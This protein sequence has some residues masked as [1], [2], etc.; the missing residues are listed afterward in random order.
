MKI[1]DIECTKN[2][3]FSFNGREGANK[4]NIKVGIDKC[5]KYWSYLY[6]NIS[7][8]LQNKE[9]VEA[10]L[11]LYKIPSRC[12]KLESEYCIAPAKEFV[13]K[14]SYYYKD[15][16]SIDND[17]GIEFTIKKDSCCVEIDITK[18]VEAII[19]GEIEN[20]G[21]LLLGNEKSKYIELSGCQKESYDKPFV[22]VKYE[23]HNYV[24]GPS[25]NLPVKIKIIDN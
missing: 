21:M 9:I 14:Y 6:F 23:E 20:K 24:D 11:I 13:S 22:R 18:I 8:S 7:E 25:V 5:I 16:I 4:E 3:T 15:T 2:T 1:V 12:G 10:K 17:L 19:K